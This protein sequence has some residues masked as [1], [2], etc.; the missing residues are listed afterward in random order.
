M[1]DVIQF[2]DVLRTSVSAKTSR[3]LAQIGSVAGRTV[4]GVNAEWWQHVGFRSRPGKPVAGKESARAVVVRRGN[5]D[6]VIA[7]EDDRGT[8]LEGNLKEG[9]TIVYAGGEDGTAQGRVIIKQDGSVT[10]FT[11]AD[12][13]GAGQSVY[14]RAAP[15]GFMWVAPWGT[16]R[17]DALGFHLLHASGASINLGGI[18]GLPAPLDTL[19]SYIKL[20]AGSVSASSMG[21][22]IADATS[23]AT[24][25]AALQTQVS[26]LLGA[27]VGVG[28]AGTPTDN[29]TR[30]VVAAALAAIAIPSATATSTVGVQT[31]LIPKGTGMT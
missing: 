13:T 14:F 18:A 25:I 8:E 15:D 26:L 11:T 5:V 24:A 22:A 31:A 7:S 20:Q 2:L 12:N 17:F 27:L 4:D 6:A 3:I 9:E 21:S 28:A 29:V 30:A 1:N 16:L 23:T 10:M 19:G